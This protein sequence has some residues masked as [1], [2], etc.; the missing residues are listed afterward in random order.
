M[1]AHSLDHLPMCFLVPQAI[2]VSD[3]LV[4][5]LL[6]TPKSMLLVG[7]GCEYDMVSQ[8]GM[9]DREPISKGPRPGKIERRDRLERRAYGRAASAYTRR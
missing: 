2:Q 1:S 9:G 7:A 4:V 3:G 5:R 8:D 6:Q